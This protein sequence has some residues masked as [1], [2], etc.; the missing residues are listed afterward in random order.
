MEGQC[1]VKSQ[2]RKNVFE[3]Q[4]G[5]RIYENPMISKAVSLILPSQEITKSNIEKWI[6]MMLFQILHQLLIIIY[7]RMKETLY[8]L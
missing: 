8:R 5:Y 6:T 2:R 1:A 3:Y 7:T 4:T